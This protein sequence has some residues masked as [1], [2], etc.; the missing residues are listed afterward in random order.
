MKEVAKSG[1][2]PLAGLRQLVEPVRGEPWD[3]GLLDRILGELPAERR[4]LLEIL[5]REKGINLVGPVILARRPDEE[6]SPLSF[7]QERLWFLQQLEPADT[8]YN[9]TAVYRISGDLEVGI[10]ARALGEIVHRHEVM[11]TRFALVR[12][13]PVQVV[14]PWRPLVL[15][16]IDL[17]ALEPGLRQGLARELVQESARLPFGLS[18]GPLWRVMLYQ[19]GPR[20][21]LAAAC[22]HHIISD[23]WSFG[24]LLREIGSL[25]GAYVSGEESPLPEL[26]VQYRDFA[27]WQRSWLRGEALDREVAYWRE[28]LG[29]ATPLLELPTDRPRPTMRS[30]QGDVERV[31]LAADRVEGLRRLAR[32]Q[33]ATL[34]MALLAAHAALLSLL[35]G[36]RGVS[37]GSPVSG[38][39]RVELEDLIGFFVNTLV[40][41]VE[42]EKG[43]SCRGLLDRVREVVLEAH[44]H[45]DLPFEKLVEELSPERSLAHVP[46]FQAAFAFQE[47]RVGVEEV[48]VPGLLLQGLESPTAGAKF[49]LTLSLSETGEEVAG[50]WEY[51]VDLFDRSTVR[52][53]WGYFERLVEEMVAE[54]E[55]G[56]GSLGLL[57]ESERHQLVCEWNDT[58]LA[59]DWHRCL[60]ELVAEQARWVPDAVAVVF[61]AAA[62]SYGELERRSCRFARRL[63]ALGCDWESRVGVFSERSLELVPCLLGILK[64][65]S[66]YV[67]LD[68][69]HPDGRLS[70]QIED[71][72]PRVIAVQSELAKRLSGSPVGLLVLEHEI[73]AGFAEGEA[74]APPRAGESVPDAAAYVLY[75]SG[76]T[77]RPKGVMVSHRAVTN[78]LLW[79]QGVL[80]LGPE[81][82]VLQKT[83]LSFDVSLGELFPPLL[84][85]ACLEV[86][87]P[88]G[89][90]DP[91]YLAGALAERQITRVH[92]VPS[93]LRLYLESAQR[94]V[95][96]CV[97]LVQS[98][99]EALPPDLVEGFSARSAAP[100]YNLYGP[101]EAAVEVSWWRCDR[102]SA[103][104]R[105]PIGR[106]IGN[107]RLHVLDE[108]LEPVPSGVSGELYIAGV[109]LARGYLHRPELTAERFVPDPSEGEPGGRLYRTGD[110]VRQQAG[111]AIEFLGRTDHQV[112]V[113][114][115]RVELGEIE[116][117]LEEQE[118]VREAVVL[119]VGGGAGESRLAACLRMDRIGRLD[120]G[121]L[122]RR[123]RDKL[124]ASMI[125][126]ALLE[127]PTLPR[128]ASGKVDRRSLAALAGAGEPSPVR[129]FRAPR[130]AAEDLVASVWSEL[131]GV[132]R[133]GAED[134]FFDL[135]GHSLLAVRALARLRE[136]FGVELPLRRLFEHPSVRGL[137]AVLE[138]ERQAGSQPVSPPLARVAREG[139]LPVSFAQQR[140]WLIDRLEPGS[141]AYNM[142]LA[143][144]VR[145]RLGPGVLA[146]CL[147]ELERRHE[148]LRTRFTHHEG[149]PL[150]EVQAQ[151]IELAVVDLAGLAAARREPEAGR[152]ARLASLLPFDLERGPLWRFWLLRAS[153]E[154]SVAAVCLHH[155]ASDG[156]SLEILLRETAALYGAYASGRPSPLPEPAVQYV[157]FA[158]WQRVWLA[159]E[160]LEGE[161][162][163]WRQRLGGAP[164]LLELP[165]DRQ[166]PAVRGRRG[167]V[168]RVRWTAPQAA[169]LRRLARQEGT[170]LYMALLAVYAALLARLSGQGDVSVGS[171]VSGRPRVE[172]EGRIGF[173][174]NTLVMRVEVDRGESARGLLGRVK[175]V[176]LDAHA[177]Q[178]LP[179]E[180]LVEELSPERSLSYTPLFQAVLAYQRQD[181]ARALA[182]PSDLALEPFALE[183][184]APKF[185]LTLS[186]TEAE[187][188]LQGGIEYDAALFD[189][190]TVRRWA[191]HFVTLASALLENPGSPVAALPLLDE[192]ERHQVG[193]EMAAGVSCGPPLSVHEVFAAQ[194][195]LTPDA[196]A[197]VV[198]GWALTY[199]ELD[200]RAAGL[201]AHLGS[202]GVGAESWVG[203]RLERCPAMVLAMLA[204]LKAGGAYLPLDPAYPVER[205]AFMLEQAGARVLIAGEIAAEDLSGLAPALL[206]LG[207]DG[208]PAETLESPQ[209]PLRSAVHPANAAY[210][211]YTSGS[212]GRPKGVVIPHANVVRLFSATE[213]WFGF[214]TGDVWT[215][216]HSFAFD[217][218]VWETWGALLHGGR[219]VLVPPEVSRDPDAF[220]ELL[221][222]EGVTVLNQTP[223]A[224]R[225]LLERLEERRLPALRVVVFGG[226]EL[227]PELLRPW[228]ERPGAPRLVNMYGI[229]ETTVHV[230]CRPVDVED[231]AP[232]VGSAIGRPIPDLG[233]C[234]L[235][236]DQQPVPL[237]VAGEI[238]VSG[239]GLARGYHARPDLTAERFLPDPFGQSPGGRLYRSGDRA[240]LRAGGEVEYLGR[241]DQMSLTPNSKVDRRALAALAAAEETPVG[242]YRAPRTPAE[243]LLASVWADLLGVERVG[244]DDNFF[245]LGGHSF[246]AVRLMVRLERLF[247]RRLPLDVLF[248]APTIAAMAQL[249]RDE[250]RRETPPLV[251]I[252]PHGSHSPFFCASPIGGNVLCYAGLA[253]SLGGEQPFYALR[254]RG[255]EGEEEPHLSI[256][257][258]AED[259]M[260]WIRVAQPEGTYR[261]GGWSFGGIV[262]LEAGRRLVAAGKKVATIVLMDSHRPPP[263]LRAHLSGQEVFRGFVRDFAGVLGASEGSFLEIVR[264]REDR[265]EALAALHVQAGRLGLL[266]EDVR[267]ADLRRFQRVYEANLRAFGAY[268]PQ[269]YDGRVLLLRPRDSE[270]REGWDGLLRGAFEVRVVSGDH[271]T[272]LRPPCV[273]TLGEHVRR[274]LDQEAL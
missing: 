235:D 194:A 118:G 154:E 37:I 10:L 184:L 66:A 190:G 168:E 191:A 161:V 103:G 155:I 231:L 266:P 1:R 220:S 30:G 132:E 35:S 253:Q 102:S 15:T 106:P 18:V 34:Y 144:R 187:G 83:P 130:T 122:R 185:D 114:G 90:R 272:M 146:R 3:S 42:V 48:S 179:F 84:A 53:W 31:R 71:S 226:E 82:R 245:D 80:P 115:V 20:E 167:G 221:V 268:R 156:E 196:V 65:G 244:V 23:G 178:D 100:L 260:A 76:S 142:P 56:V 232:A 112:K 249:L 188:L 72:S 116:S 205:A 250:L 136:A 247:S 237:G 92:F 95:P 74:V 216:F 251:A 26:P 70:L 67:P 197:L 134:D 28:R 63:A 108:G 241:L 181:G 182:L 208:R 128:L 217:F 44:A 145:G 263:D 267:L 139:G 75:T 61:G 274:E 16:R 166:R 239:V 265:D 261:I 98:S 51:S 93:M 104:R 78:R 32:Q 137:A 230:T 222:E 143:L 88:G 50:S 33:G 54:P 87:L 41:R 150:Q 119:E 62:L 89:H 7:E 259:F 248:R 201:A 147:R 121:D 233:L 4:R 21:H 38:R 45:Q 252:Q 177:H 105:V 60:H 270:M 157:D 124:P 6:P 110:R 195:C 228:L 5:L 22:L 223:S 120:A 206:R 14:E 171:P 99:G 210:M 126:E 58:A 111:G 9:L 43:E 218:S 46:L 117:V 199:G 8:S 246:L 47:G 158:V 129:A 125:P 135:G 97:G 13:E 214:G 29:G 229:T 151:G 12:G 193:V 91:A 101:T 96:S 109:N 52:R 69:E 254:A 173:F 262:A 213:P 209:E 133:V 215:L 160:V 113:R 200:R 202:L 240:R 219:L 77:G 86:A 192:S 19:V 152:L 57:A 271:Y 183:G 148:V 141:S 159:G 207:W 204:V 85:G 131:L 55:R 79:M 17:T 175:E 36:Q 172:L 180:K 27:V 68:P 164:P 127:V 138:Q 243:E 186:V 225:Q 189:A 238:C 2:D 227:R 257:E 234:V 169:G 140:L 107:V 170:T 40:M 269:P 163:Y 162:A 255:L 203:L 49:D 212:T 258:M 59:A 211:I 94:E 81:D 256:E 149:V 242:T 24:I 174:V 153:G 264:D 11:R 25:Y 224:F 64:A 176:V 123:L 39:R 198:S 73:G 236:P 165:A 273:E